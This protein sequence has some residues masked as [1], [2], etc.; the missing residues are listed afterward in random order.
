MNA[1]LLQLARTAFLELSKYVILLLFIIYT[2]HCF[3]VFFQS[4]KEAK[5]KVFHRQ[6]VMMYVIHFLCSMVLFVNAPGREIVYYYLAQLAFLLFVSKAYIYVY[7]N[8]SKVVLNNML[9]LLT[10]GFLM[11]ERLKPALCMRQMMFAFAISVLGL[12]IP[13]LIEKFRYFDRLGWIYAAMG[14]CFLGLVFVIGQEKYGSKN[15]I[16]F[17]G[18][19][20]QPSEFVKILFVFFAAALLA[21]STHFIDVVKVTALAAVHVLI[22]VAEKDLGAALIYFVTYLLILYIA[23]ENLGYL[24]LG[25]AAGVAASV[26]AYHLF[27]HVQTRVTAWRDP[28]STIDTKGY[29]VAQSL[30]AIGTGGWFGLGLFQG[31]PTKIPV[32]DEDFVFAAISEEMGGIFAICVI[33]VCACCYLMFLNIAMQIHERFYKL[34][35]LGLGTTY[36]FQVFLTIGGVIK[37]IPSTGVT[38]PLVSYGGSSL[39]S[40]FIIFAVIQGLYIIRED[41]SVDEEKENIRRRRSVSE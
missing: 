3:T 15:W 40:T 37:F 26:V 18:I 41:E 17:G 23:S 16:Q 19:A 32:A 11:I 12:F 21:R 5:D 38:L 24:L 30:F 6:H 22:L 36:G 4:S 20:L 25:I 1:N 9:M 2:W 34:I 13:F 7:T 28:W 10:L 8:L 35:A 39:L 29:Q 27:D 33:L 31:M 14:I